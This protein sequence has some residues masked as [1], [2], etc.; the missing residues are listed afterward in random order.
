MVELEQPRLDSYT[1]FSFVFMGGLLVLMIVLHLATPFVAA[2]F[3]YLALRLLSRPRRVG[4]WPAV[5]IFLAA[6]AGGAYGLGYFIHQTTHALPEIADKAIPSIIDTAQR[7]GIELPF[8]DYDSFKDL[9]FETVKSQVSYLGSFAKAARGATSQIVFLLAGCVVAISLFL[10][11]QFQTGPPGPLNNVY[12]KGCAAISRRFVVLYQSFV[13]IMGAQIVISA[14]NTVL[15]AIFILAVH[16]PYAVVVIGVSFLSG[17]VPVIGN[18]ISNTIIVGIGFTISPKMAFIALL[19]LV[20]IH[21]LEYFLNSKIIGWRIQNPLW[22][23]LLGLIVGERLLGLAGLVLAPVILYYIKLEAAAI[24]A[25]P[26]T[27]PGLPGTFE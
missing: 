17:L 26:G 13:T 24:K 2:L 1:R 18:L 9:A 23:T 3:A 15:T 11:P 7:H 22:L 4:R 6:L 5:V 8:T 20:A 25:E 21:K 12:V 19:F 10:N 27:I 14:I 16:L